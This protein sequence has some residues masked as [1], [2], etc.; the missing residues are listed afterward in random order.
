MARVIDGATL[1]VD[2]GSDFPA[3]L[4][5][6]TVRVDGPSAEEYRRNGGDIVS[7][8]LAGASSIVIRSPRYGDADCECQVVVD[9]D[10]LWMQVL[11]QL[12]RP[13]FLPD[14]TN[15]PRPHR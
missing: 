4:S 7:E 15:R 13:V 12:T 2:A 8:L 11:L 9:G 10:F 5:M 14:E 6:L 1:V 3:E